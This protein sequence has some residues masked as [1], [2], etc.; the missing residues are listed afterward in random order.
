MP[1]R[2]SEKEEVVADMAERLRRA[3]AVVVTDYRGLSVADLQALR[4]KLRTSGSEFTVIK[5]TLVK[6]AFEVAELEAPDAYLTGPT[7][8]ALLYDDLSGPTKVLQ[9]FAKSTQILAIKGGV[10]DGRTLDAKAMSAL[11]DLPTREELYATFMGVLQA[12]MRQYVT[13]V[14]A[15]LRNLLNVMS[16]RARDEGQSAAA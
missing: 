9:E 16:A 7:A 8:V 2:R 4:R 12:P 3:Q 5:N 10:L 11:A 1:L 6:R 15:P 14:A 13:V